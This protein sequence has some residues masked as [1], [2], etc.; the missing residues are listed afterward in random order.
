VYRLIP[1]IDNRQFAKEQVKSRM[2]DAAG[3]YHDVDLPRRPQ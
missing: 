1:I 2:D 3:G